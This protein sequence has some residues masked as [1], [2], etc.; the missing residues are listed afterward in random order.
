MSEQSEHPQEKNYRKMS[1][2]YDKEADKAHGEAKRMLLEAKR[3]RD[4]GEE[5]KAKWLRWRSGELH[6]FADRCRKTSLKW[7]NNSHQFSDPNW[8]GKPRWD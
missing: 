3:A 2:Y 7:L 1:E 8:D 6:R 5:R 4:K